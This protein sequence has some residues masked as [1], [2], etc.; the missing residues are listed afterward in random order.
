MIYAATCSGCHRGPR[1]MPFGGID[2]AL[3]SGIAAPSAANL[4]NVVL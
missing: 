2:L 3:S 4:I 1:A